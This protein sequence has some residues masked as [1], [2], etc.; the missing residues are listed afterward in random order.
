MQSGYSL[1]IEQ[2]VKGLDLDLVE[3]TRSAGGLLRVTIELPHV[4]GCPEQFVQ[5][6][7]CERVTRQLQ[8]ALEVEGVDYSRLEVSS[9]GI[10]RLLRHEQD[11]ARF[12]G[13]VVDITLKQPIGQAGQV[14]GQGVTVSRRKF[15]G[16][17]EATESDWQIVWRDEPKS[18]KPGAKVSQ[19]KLDA[20]VQNVLGFKWSE[21]KEARLAPIVNFKGR[22][23]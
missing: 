8:Y 23:N 16:T 3:I 14:A 2:T 21:I 15:R 4:V 1:I 11:L 12:V 13:E 9:P 7:D 5:V 19:K 22:G 10:D 6:E 20:A 17:L 18:L